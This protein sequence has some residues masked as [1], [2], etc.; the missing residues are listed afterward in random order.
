MIILCS[1]KAYSGSFAPTG[2]SIWR[3]IHFA[4]RTRLLLAAITNKI[5]VWSVS[6]E[7]ITLSAWEI[8]AA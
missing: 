5:V 8:F 1:V 2:V 7:T 4:Q 6:C 3:L